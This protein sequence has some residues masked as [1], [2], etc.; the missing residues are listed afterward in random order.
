MI[1]QFLLTI[2]HSVCLHVC[3]IQT[4]KPR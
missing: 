3:R 2:Q 1:D 4:S